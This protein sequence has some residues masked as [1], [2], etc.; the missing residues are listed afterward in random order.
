MQKKLSPISLALVRE[1]NREDLPTNDKKISVNPLVAEVAKWY[2]KV[3]NAMD[4]R[5]DAADY[6]NDE[7]ILRSA[8]ERIVKRRLMLGNSGEK[9]AQSLVRELVWARYFP[10]NT[11]PEKVIE[12]VA[13]KINLY[14]SLSEKVTSHS[15][16]PKKKTEE[17]IFEVMSADIT[18]ILHPYKEIKN[19]ANFMFQ[20]LKGQVILK[21]EDEE[22]K[23]VQVFIAIRKTL[24]KEDLGLLRFDLFYQLFGG[25][26][27]ENLNEVAA[28]FLPGYQKIES[29]LNYP[30][31]DKIYTYVKNQT[32]PF[33][34]LEDI[35]RK[36]QKDLPRIL[37]NE[38]E[39]ENA[40]LGTCLEHYREI[41]VKV[42]RAVLR[43]IIFLFITKASLALAVEG[44]FESFVYGKVIW[45]SIALNTSAPPF[46]MLLVSM[47]IKT[48]DQE[49]SKRILEK[50]KAVLFDNQPFR[51]EQVIIENYPKSNPVLYIV[52]GMLWVLACILGFG[53]VVFILSKL[54]FNIVSQGVFV[55][56]LAIVSFFAYRIDQ[57]ARIYTMAEEKQSWRMLL[58]DFLFMPFIQ[59]GR[60]LTVGI[61]KANILIVM[62]D[63]LIE[64][65]FKELF[66][67]FE[68][69]FLFLRSQREK[70]G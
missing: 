68:H 52:Y 45:G 40:V 14:V 61:S 51:K 56:F 4:Y 28:G 18:Q 5:E 35:L 3:R 16:L 1:F 49:N 24:A 62:F 43:S 63:L 38:V 25:L 50:I 48:P 57:T 22:T 17:W 33:F 59:V 29:L 23:D 70:L 27:K 64:T 67:F 7:V 19:M 2:E 32:P 12:E 34:I 13:E 30:L 39:L 6:R 10:D 36:H 20:L 65:P 15:D 37:N 26:T 44:S 41:K 9:A 21:G 54:H 31:K 42:R 55:F 11:I 46:L 53:V 58:F 60:Q 47:F 8:I 69:W 66:A